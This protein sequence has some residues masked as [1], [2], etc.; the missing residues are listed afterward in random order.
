MWRSAVCVVRLR[1]GAREFELCGCFRRWLAGVLHDA[2]PL[3][4]DDKDTGNDLY[5]AQ[6]GCPEGEADAQWMNGK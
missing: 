3:T 4:A 5:M 2:A 1:G 6:I